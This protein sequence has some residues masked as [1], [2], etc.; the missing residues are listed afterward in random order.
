V[1]M[2]DAIALGGE[3]P[4]VTAASLVVRSQSLAVHGNGCWATRA[5]GRFH[6]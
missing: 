4:R 6:G 3:I 5:W 2:K 1:T